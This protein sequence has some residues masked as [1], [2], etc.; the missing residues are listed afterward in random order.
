M[1]RVPPD[2][3]AFRTLAAP[4]LDEDDLFAAL[5]GM[6][7]ELLWGGGRPSAFDPP[8]SRA[9]WTPEEE[10]SRRHVEVLS[11]WPVVARES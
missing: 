7:G 1:S 4:G 8:E 6:P 2:D 3:V 11:R 5:C 9:G 10:R